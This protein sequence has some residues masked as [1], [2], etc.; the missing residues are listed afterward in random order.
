LLPEGS[1]PKGSAQDEAQKQKPNILFI[2][3]DD[4]RPQLG[5]YGAP[6]VKSP[7]IDALARQGVLFESAY[8]QQAVCSPSRVSVMT[9]LRPDSTKVWDLVTLFRD[10][11]PEV[12]TLPQHFLQYDYH[13]ESIGKIFHKPPMQDDEKSWSVPSVRP[14]T[15]NWT[16]PS[17]KAI[18]RELVA[19][20]DAQGVT[21]KSRYYATL[22]P[23]TESAEVADN[24]YTDGLVADATLVSLQKLAKNPDQP[25]F[26]AV[27]FV[28]PHLPFCA[29]T[30]YWELY[31]VDDFEPADNPYLPSDCGKYAPTNWGELR[32]YY[33]MPDEGPVSDDQAK[34]LIHAYC[35]C[36]SYVDAQVGR[37]LAEL[38]RLGLSENTVVVLWGDHGWK[39]GEHGLWAKHTNFELDAR[40]PFI[41]SAPGFQGKG[42][43]SPALVELVDIYPTLCELAGLPL[44]EGLEGLSLVPLLQQPSQPW[45]Q[46]TFTQWP[47]GNIMGHSIKTDRYRYTQWAKRDTGQVLERELYDHLHDSDE[48]ENLANQPEQQSLV[49]Q[50]S[51]QL[52]AG[53]QQALPARN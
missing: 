40:V 30:K 26:L 37:V 12:I 49:A 43:A 25:F 31:D 52:A 46:A 47:H 17:S 29:P 28:K 19:A 50:L 14:S 34:H 18:I 2:A 7:H 1:S 53:W 21:G 44:P 5:C 22:G 13:T 33:G 20:A 16:T 4:L 35:A 45:K 23:V 38:E 3:I 36:V 24:G 9:G 32:T 11:I 8:C 39:L 6:L 10:V 51:A 48:N 41:V 15:S 42:K 27:G